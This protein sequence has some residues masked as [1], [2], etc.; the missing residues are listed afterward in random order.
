MNKEDLA[1]HWTKAQPVVAGF[2][3]TLVPDLNQADDILQEVAVALVRKCSSFDPGKGSFTGWAIG[4]AR[5]EVSRFRKGRAGESLV[6][7]QGLVDRIERACEAIEPELPQIR[8][9]LRVCMEQRN[10]SARE[11]L[12]LRYAEGLRPSLIAERIRSTSGAVRAALH[13]IRNALR[14]CIETRLGL[15]GG[16]G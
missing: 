5:I 2:I 10:S 12:E 11:M 16:E 4:M 6:F 3:A 9:A 7:D 1:R 13:R 15:G 8:S 14:T